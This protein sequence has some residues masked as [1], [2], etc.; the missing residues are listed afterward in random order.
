MLDIFLFN[1]KHLAVLKNDFKQIYG[2][3]Y[4]WSTFN[5]S[6]YAPAHM[7]TRNVLHV[8]ANMHCQNLL[9]L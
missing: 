6:A 8:R 7:Y 5:H 4:G 9:I 2:G 3:T 1:R